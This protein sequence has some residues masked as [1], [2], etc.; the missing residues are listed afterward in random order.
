[1][2]KY[3]IL[4][5][6]SLIVV[7][8]CSSTK[9]IESDI[10][11]KEFKECKDLEL[12]NRIKNSFSPIKKTKVDSVKNIYTLFEN[13]L[14]QKKI[15]KEISKNG[16]KDLLEK[17]FAKKI[18]SKTIF[19][20]CEIMQTD[21]LMFFSPLSIKGCFGNTEY[22]Y[23]QLKKEKNGWKYNFVLIIDKYE[24]EGGFNE[25]GLE[26]L[27]KSIDLIPDKKFNMEIYRRYIL[28]LVGTKGYHEQ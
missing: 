20:F 15:L 9:Q 16:Y 8:S 5:I 23:N 7:N 28:A 17:S 11:D 10:W 13:F 19:E 1:M 4:L 25:N 12:S 27:K 22:R 3:Y 26:I 21:V 14:L 18:T 6:I 2:T 24:S